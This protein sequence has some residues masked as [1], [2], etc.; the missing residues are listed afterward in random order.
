MYVPKYE[1]FRST[2]NQRRSK[3]FGPLPKDITQINFENLD[4]KYTTTSDGFPLLR[5]D[6][7]NNNCRIVIFASDTQIQWLASSQRYHGDGTFKCAET[8]FC[9]LYIFHGYN[10][11]YDRMFP[12]AYILLQH[13]DYQSYDTTFNQLKTLAN[14]NSMQL[15]PSHCLTDFETAAM[16]ALR[17]QFPRSAIKGCYFHFKQAIIRWIC[18][19]GK[20][21]I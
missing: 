6:N 2:L 1:N 5:F 4:K 14:D 19:N 3:E 18:Q 7:L 21:F 11:V 8:H 15:D 20:L 9:Q 10:E 13:K 12:C 17:H 16:Q